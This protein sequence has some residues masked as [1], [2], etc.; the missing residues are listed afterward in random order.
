MTSKKPKRKDMI[1]DSK[2]NA[3]NAAAVFK[4]P[5]S[6]NKAFSGQQDDADFE[7]QFLWSQPVRRVVGRHE[8]D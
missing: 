5:A 7:V 3:D 1:A 4:A 2:Q 6:A 8:I